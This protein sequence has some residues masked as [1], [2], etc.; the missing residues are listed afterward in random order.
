MAEDDSK[1]RTIEEEGF[2]EAPLLTVPEAARYLGLGRRLVYELIERGEITAV[3][4]R[5]ATLIDKESLDRFRASGR[6]A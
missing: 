5:G 1:T 3:K 4:R 2:V 6:L